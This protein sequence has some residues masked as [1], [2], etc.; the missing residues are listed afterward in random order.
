M[1]LVVRQGTAEE[2]LLLPDDA[3]VEGLESLLNDWELA[4]KF[5]ITEQLME[6]AQL[7]LD[8]NEWVWPTVKQQMEG[9]PFST[10]MDGIESCILVLDEPPQQP[11]VEEK[12]PVVNALDV[13][14]EALPLPAGGI[15]I[16]Q[17][18][19][20]LSTA[21]DGDLAATLVQ[22][23]GS[24]ASSVFSYK[25]SSVADQ[26]MELMACVSARLSKIPQLMRPPM[27]Q[28]AS[29]LRL[30]LAV[31]VEPKAA[32]QTA[33]NEDSEF[34][35]TTK[36]KVMAAMARVQVADDKRPE[37]MQRLL[38]TGS[39]TLVSNYLPPAPGKKNGGT[40]DCRC[41]GTIILGGSMDG[42]MRHVCMPKHRTFWL[43]HTEADARPSS[44]ELHASL[45]SKWVPDKLDA[46]HETY[47]A[48]RKQTKQ[49]NEARVEKLD[50]TK[51]Q[52]RAGEMARAFLQG[53]GAGSPLPA[54]D[55]A[56]VAGSP[57]ALAA[58]Q[59]A[60]EP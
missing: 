30:K 56:A 44:K 41:S 5:T 31:G 22:V 48:K 23:P 12:L 33:A 29:E 37:D 46:E 51:R 38:T 3:L 28:A 43:S 52:K 1:L 25:L 42:L 16:T 21:Y 36:R 47:V 26:A 35:T 57:A 58:I 60:L 49:A 8:G 32:P 24:S 2:T 40:V 18:T 13:P 53:T 54:P 14:L 7:V 50:K 10:L 11:V 19:E 39:H 34:A 4:S 27:P 45:S 9:T 55:L 17:I 59:D 6:K 20:L 15:T